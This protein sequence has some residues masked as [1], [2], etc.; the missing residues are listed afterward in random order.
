ML[1]SK[2]TH[3]LGP[4]PSH[5]LARM[6][7]A[8]LI[9]FNYFILRSLKD[10][11]VITEAK[12]AFIL[13]SLKLWLVFPG[14]FFAS[15]ILA[16]L[17]KKWP[18]RRVFYSVI[19][20][21]LVFF[22]IF[23][24]GIFPRFPSM[25]LSS[26]IPLIQIW[27]LS[28]FYLI[29][30]LWRVLAFVLFWSFINQRS[31]LSLAKSTYGLLMF[32]GSIGGMGANLLIAFLPTSFETTM[33]LCTY[34]LLIAGITI[35]FLYPLA[36][37]TT[38]TPQPKPSS[39]S[40]K[41]P[42]GWIAL[43]VIADYASFYLIE[44]LW[45]EVIYQL[46]STPELFCRYHAGVTFWTNLASAIASL[47][48]TS[49][50]AKRFGWTTLAL[51]APLLSIIAASLFI[52]NLISVTTPTML[53]LTLGSAH[54]LISRLGRQVFTSPAKE[55]VYLPLS[56][57]LQSSGKSLVDG[58]NVAMGK[59]LGALIHK[60]SVYTSS[61]LQQGGTLGLIAIGMTLSTLGIILKI[62][63]K[64]LKPTDAERVISS[65]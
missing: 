64:P 46:Y 48:L 53:T 11:L 19:L 61:L 52:S 62:R 3:F 15:L 9:C 39:P 8:F 6:G 50:I 32:A 55:M 20:A 41:N 16:Y 58:N 24:F 44:V 18:Q 35:L 31:S 43:W 38:N 59:S 34:L 49:M 21:F 65:T 42:L 7:M 40:I 27:P 25:C 33:T 13:S 63:G 4:Y 5:L 36:G 2:L 17:Y 37:Q 56:S 14:A 51:L 57:D 47:S 29:A 45:K 60:G 30:E 12:G 22:G 28:L 23:G 10:T 26:S 1:K 54:N